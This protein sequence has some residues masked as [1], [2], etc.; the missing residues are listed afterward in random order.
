MIDPQS[1]FSIQNT[2]EFRSVA[3]EVFR[4]QAEH[5]PP[6]RE[7]VARW[8]IDPAQVSDIDQIPFLPIEFFKSRDVYAGAKEPQIVFTSSATTG[9]VPSRHPV[10]DLSI[11]EQ[12]FSQTFSLFYGDPAD[13]SIFALLPNYLERSG[14]S[15]VY[16]ADRLM[17]MGEGG[18][19]FLHGYSELVRQMEAAAGQG[20]KILLLGV[21]FAL[22]EL[23]ENYRFSLP[24]LT[25]METGGMKGR[26]KEITREELHT[27]LC[28]SFGVEK[29]ASEYGMAEL[30]SQAYSAGEGLFRTPPWMAVRTRDVYDPT[31]TLPA[32]RSGGINVIDLANLYSCSFIETQDMGVRYPDG[33]FRVLGRLDKSEIR[34]C[35]LMISE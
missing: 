26:R 24:G 32:G 28:R 21:S 9:Q 14:S 3:L 25:V 16:M 27:I 6:Y 29:I 8:G 22:W 30:L 5:C 4:F 33:S 31:C 23:A 1:I 11:Y 20:R 17:A 13:Y 2:E 34:G 7:Y 35:N 12:S 10:A 15:L 19:F 18:G